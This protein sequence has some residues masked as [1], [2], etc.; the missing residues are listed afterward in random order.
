MPL[1]R[2]TVPRNFSGKSSSTTTHLLSQ[3]KQGRG[4]GQIVKRK[5]NLL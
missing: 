2:D 4:V 5:S 3:K 1:S